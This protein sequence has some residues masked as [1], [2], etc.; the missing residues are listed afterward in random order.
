MVSHCSKL[1]K[2]NYTY[3][4][5]VFH[6][7]GKSEIVRLGTWDVYVGSEPV[8]RAIFIPARSASKTK[9]ENGT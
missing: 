1:G 2:E 6:K 4:Q 3:L 8:V 5:C 7:Q 9:R